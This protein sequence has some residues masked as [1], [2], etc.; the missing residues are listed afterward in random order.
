M[1]AKGHRVCY[2]RSSP[3]TVESD[4][5]DNNSPEEGVDPIPMDSADP[6]SLR[7]CLHGLVSTTADDIAD[8]DYDSGESEED[9]ELQD[10]A[11]GHSESNDNGQVATLRR[12]I[13]D[14]LHCIMEEQWEELESDGEI[15]DVQERS[16]RRRLHSAT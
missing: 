10:H 5:E 8:E 13:N 4:E 15:K 6:R 7:G 11:S 2:Q 14:G 9:D 12:N 1:E 3:I 16:R